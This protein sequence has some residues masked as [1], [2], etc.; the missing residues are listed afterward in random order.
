M[1]RPDTETLRARVIELAGDALD[2]ATTVAS[3]ARSRAGDV[4]DD[5]PARMKAARAVT[6]K[7]ASRRAEQLSSGSKD[8]AKRARQSQVGEAI[9]AGVGAMLPLLPELMKH[10]SSRTVAVRTARRVAPVAMR[11]HPAVALGSIAVSAGV[12]AYAARTWMQRR[13][14]DEKGRAAERTRSM[15]LDDDQGRMDDEGGD[16]GGY[17]G[18][19]RTLIDS[20]VRTNGATRRR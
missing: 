16:P 15:S 18:S 4:A 14:A 11:A 3:E 1:H 19:P 8:A 2:M 9:G 5:A 12:A 20:A 6:A 17:D 10:R 13:H 7:V